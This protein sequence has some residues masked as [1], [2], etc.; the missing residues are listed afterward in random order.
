[1]NFGEAIGELL[2]GNCR[3]VRRKAWND[4]VR[5][6]LDTHLKSRY[7]VVVSN[8]GTIPWIP[9]MVEMCINDDWEM[10]G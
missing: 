8:K 6:E 9:N 5:I 7:F 2:C 1:M 10:L 4:D 3:F